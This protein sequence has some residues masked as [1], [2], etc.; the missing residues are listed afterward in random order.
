MGT[1]GWKIVTQ[2]PN[3]YL[4]I[5]LMLVRKKLWIIGL[6]A[7]IISAIVS[8]LIANNISAPIIRLRNI[9]SQGAEGDLTVRT[10]F[11]RNDEIGQAADSFNKMMEKISQLTYND[12]LTGLLSLSYFK[13]KLRFDLEKIKSQDQDLVLFSIGIND[14][15]TIKDNFGHYIGNQ[16]LK[17]IATRIER[18]VGDGVYIA[19]ANKEFFF[20]WKKEINEIEFKKIAK[21][22]STEINRKYEING[23]IIHVKASLGIA[24]YPE[25]GRSSQRLI[26]NAGLAQHLVAEQS[27][28][29]IQVYSPG[30]EEELSEKMRLEAKLKYAL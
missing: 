2:V 18:F 15:E 24:V 26:K 25:S 14:F 30:M 8:I 28:D 1:D 29:S 6:A 3:D 13:D 5:P 9:F 17:K 22:I 11:N 21:E 23:Q 12:I 19:R 27:G 4:N 20:Y 7:I 10:T 16:V